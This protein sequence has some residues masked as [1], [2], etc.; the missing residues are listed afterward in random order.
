MSGEICAVF[1]CNNYKLQKDPRSFFRFPRDKIIAKEKERKKQ[2]KAEARSKNLCLGPS[3]KIL[4]SSTMAKSSCKIRVAIDLSF[5]D[6]MTDKALSKCVK[7]VGHCYS[8]NRRAK[9]PMQLYITSFNG[10][11]KE[12]MA[13]NVGYGNWDIHFR[14]ENYLD[15][16]KKDDVVYL[17]SESENVLSSLSEDKVYVIGGLV[18]HNA[19]KGLTFRLAEEHNINHCQLPLQKYLH[20]SSRKVL[21]I[22]HV[23]EILLGV[24]EGM[25]WKDAFLRVLPARKGA[26]ERDSNETRLSPEMSAVD[27]TL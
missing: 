6:L 18:D 1:G 26:V 8:L 17:C 20:M 27:V 19:H 2:R 13:K 16:F 3:R 9:N 11:S 21:T 12:Q 4:K 22:D 15:I 24:S 7:Q 25:S 14:T 5:D 23:F 10:K